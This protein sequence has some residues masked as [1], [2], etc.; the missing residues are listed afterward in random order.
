MIRVVTLFHDLLAII[1]ELVL[2]VGVLTM[3]LVEVLATRRSRLLVRRQR[4]SHRLC[5]RHG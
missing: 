3:L 5:R 4:L 1:Q 2:G